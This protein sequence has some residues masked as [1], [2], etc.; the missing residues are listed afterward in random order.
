MNLGQDSFAFNLSSI[1][2][3]GNLRS[4]ALA[5]SLP[6]ELQ[7]MILHHALFQRV[8]EDQMYP[9]H[10]ALVCARWHWL[11]APYLVRNLRLRSFHQLSQIPPERLINVESLAVTECR[12]SG[13]WFHRVALSRSIQKMVA[14]VSMTRAVDQAGRGQLYDPPLPPAF[15]N[16][17]PILSRRGFSHVQSLSMVNYK[18]KSWLAFAKTIICLPSL[19]N[20]ELSAVTWTSNELE[21]PPT[22]LHSHA[23]LTTIKTNEPSTLHDLSWLL[24]DRRHPRNVLLR[25]TLILDVED[26]TRLAKIVRNL[27]ALATLSS[28]E[29]IQLCE[30]DLGQCMFF[31]ASHRYATFTH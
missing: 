11:C 8:Y 12:E 17:L 27:Q 9:T 26:I 4:L 25:P 21:S 15:A 19:I 5:R 2:G 24:F 6:P 28:Y 1:S 23:Q 22:W 20:L 31:H 3:R 14:L 30:P 10:L 13:P 16:L 18:F 7:E 29:C